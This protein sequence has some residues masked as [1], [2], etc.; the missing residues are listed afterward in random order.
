MRDL[1]PRQNQNT[2][3]VCDTANVVPP[4]F[5][6]PADV[7]VAA[8][9]VARRLGRRDAAMA[10]ADLVIGLLPAGVALQRLE[11]N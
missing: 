9:D 7:A 5:R 6:T 3:V 4:G 8:A 2:R 11:K 10:L 1:H